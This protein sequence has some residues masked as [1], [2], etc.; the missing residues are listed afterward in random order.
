M[1]VKASKKDYEK[2]TSMD[3]SKVIDTTSDLDSNRMDKD[4]HI[5]NI[6]GYEI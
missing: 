2:A 5:E 4:R 1:R 3:E 6:N